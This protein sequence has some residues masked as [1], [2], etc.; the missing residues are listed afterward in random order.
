MDSRSVLHEYRADCFT[1]MYWH[2]T[3]FFALYLDM[4]KIPAF[5]TRHYAVSNLSTNHRM[6]AA[7]ACCITKCL[8]GFFQYY[9]SSF[10]KINDAIIDQVTISSFSLR[11][12]NSHMVIPKSFIA[13]RFLYFIAL[14]LIPS[15]H[16][17]ML[18]AAKLFLLQV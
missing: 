9:F 16:L 4:H 11:W 13:S 6:S 7:G 18:P 2:Y 10:Y 5:R 14:S 15:L 8:F 3:Y 12:Q 1:F 17:I